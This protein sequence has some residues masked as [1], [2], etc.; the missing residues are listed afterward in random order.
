MFD[1]DVFYVDVQNNIPLIGHTVL[2]FL[3]L[4]LTEEM[5]IDNKYDLKFKPG[6]YQQVC[7]FLNNDLTSFISLSQQ[8]KRYRLYSEISGE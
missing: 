8:A 1:A 4:R 6:L 5:D 7:A 3:L 2:R